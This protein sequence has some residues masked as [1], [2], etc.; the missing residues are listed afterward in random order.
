MFTCVIFDYNLEGQRASKTR[1]LHVRSYHF[2]NDSLSK[3]VLTPMTSACAH[4]IEFRLKNST[5]NRP[6]LAHL[7]HFRADKFALLKSCKT[8]CGRSAGNRTF[9]RFGTLDRNS[10]SHAFC[11]KSR[12]DTHFVHSSVLHVSYNI[13]SQ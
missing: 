8:K 7:P 10:F 13:G 4:E 12:V 2:F 5:T 1:I 6:K 3:N 9:S 11:F